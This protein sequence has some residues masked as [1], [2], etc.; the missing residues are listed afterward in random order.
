QALELAFDVLAQLLGLVQL[1][2]QADRLLAQPLGLLAQR[3]QL[4][5]DGGGLRLPPRA[6]A[7][8]GTRRAGA[9]VSGRTALARGCA[10]L[11]GERARRVTA[12][13]VER[14]RRP[15]EAQATDAEPPAA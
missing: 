9:A 6:R 8:G 4:V 14:Q 12:A 7:A 13:E 1:R 2:L 15:D 5:G 3:G 10:A 11:V